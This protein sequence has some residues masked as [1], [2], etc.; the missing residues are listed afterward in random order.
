MHGATLKK[1]TVYFLAII[2]TVGKL[3]NKDYSD[4]KQSFQALFFVE[5][6]YA[7]LRIGGLFLMHACLLFKTYKV[8]TMIK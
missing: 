3:K 1:L 6:P 7:G 5:Y 8:Q 2:L 4:I